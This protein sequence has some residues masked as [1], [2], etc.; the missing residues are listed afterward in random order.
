[1]MLLQISNGTDKR[2]KQASDIVEEA[3]SIINYT[4]NSQK[5]N[6]DYGMVS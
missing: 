1:M 6:G 2:S 4:L 3:I 5:C